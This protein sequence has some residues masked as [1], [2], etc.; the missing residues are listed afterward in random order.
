MN[1]TIESELIETAWLQEHL[2]DPDLRIIDCSVVVQHADDESFKFVLGKAEWEQGHIP[3]SIFVDVIHQL[4]DPE[5]EINMMMPTPERFTAIMM[6][7]GIGDDTRVVLYDRSNHA[8]AARVWWMLRVC[9]FDNAAILNGGWP[10]W[11]REGREES[12]KKTEYPK[13]ARLSLHY[14][15]N[16]MVDKAQVLESL[17]AENTTLIHSLPASIFTGEIQPYKRPGRIPGSKNLYCEMLVDPDS[18]TYLDLNVIRQKFAD[19]G[20]LR[21]ERV[22]TYCDGGVAASSNAFALTLL[23]HENVAVYDGSLS[24]WTNDP[25]LPMETD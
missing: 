8:W 6:E 22:I 16:L 7:L 10:K 3:G 12:M 15:P 1:C 23:G 9:G 20:A 25:D 21:S 19:T 13:A 5:H 14:R 11:R 24:E 18:R 4:S 2:R 17:H